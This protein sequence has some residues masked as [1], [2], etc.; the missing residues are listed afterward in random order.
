MDSRAGR[1]LGV[2]AANCYLQVL[3]LVPCVKTLNLVL[4]L[5]LEMVTWFLRHTRLSNSK[6]EV[7]PQ[8]P[9]SSSLSMFTICLD[10][11]KVSKAHLL[12]SLGQLGRSS[13]NRQHMV[14]GP[15]SRSLAPGLWS[16]S[17]VAIPDSWSWSLLT[18]LITAGPNRW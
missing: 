12:R 11:K 2:R 16:R 15:W 6:V 8:V 4:H 14:P 1:L 3:P 5:G 13:D 9:S 7:F 17:L 10:T 18:V